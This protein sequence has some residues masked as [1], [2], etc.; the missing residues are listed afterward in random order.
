MWVFA[1][2]RMVSSDNMLKQDL[3]FDHIIAVFVKETKYC[4]IIMKIAI[5]TLMY[6]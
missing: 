6:S 5:V 4:C 1:S 3:F 2:M